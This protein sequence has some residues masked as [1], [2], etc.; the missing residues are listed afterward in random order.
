MIDII[1]VF[2]IKFYVGREDRAMLR[3]NPSVRADAEVWAEV[4]HSG[5]SL[6]TNTYLGYNAINLN[7]P[8]NLPN[9]TGLPYGNICGRGQSLKALPKDC[10]S[11]KPV[12]ELFPQL[13]ERRST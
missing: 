9:S 11:A 7:V 2:W 12:L 3:S 1:I 6:P 13:L 10:P 4:F 8:I 5:I